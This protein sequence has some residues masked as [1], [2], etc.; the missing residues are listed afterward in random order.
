[1]TAI[2]NPRWLMFICELCGRTL[3][4]CKPARVPPTHIPTVVECSSCAVCAHT[5]KAN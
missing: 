4:D 3:S 5:K 1:M 2:V